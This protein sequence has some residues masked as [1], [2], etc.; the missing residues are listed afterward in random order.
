MRETVQ[1]LIAICFVAAGGI[2]ACGDDGGDGDG[3][4]DGDVDG[5]SDADFEIAEPEPPAPPE[6]PVLTPCP[7]GWR[8]VPADGPDG[9]ATCDPWPEGGPDECGDDEAHFPG[10]PGCTR[11]GT[12][13]PE[14]DWAEDLPTDREVVYVLAGAPEGGGGSRDAPFGSSVHE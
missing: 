7:E 6:P 4:V 11:I 5:D 9:I 13:C 12:A 3:D 14:G 2:T 10:E 8:E 1:S